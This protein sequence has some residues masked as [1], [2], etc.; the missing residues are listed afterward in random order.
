M[1]KEKVDLPGDFARHHNVV[2]I[3]KSDILSSARSCAGVSWI[4]TTAAIRLI[5]IAQLRAVS[6]DDV[7]SF[8]GGTVVNYNDINRAANLR[9]DA[10]Q[11]FFQISR[12]VIRWH[13]HGNQDL[14]NP[15]AQHL[16]LISQHQSLISGRIR[17]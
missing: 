8:I 3:E 17:L 14:F 16:S 4:G 11:T 10:I 2:R 13:N 6:S 1:P 5:N 7:R 15:Q 12:R 9:K